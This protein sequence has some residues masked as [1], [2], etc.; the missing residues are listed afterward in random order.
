M[1]NNLHTHV[2]NNINNVTQSGMPIHKIILTQSANSLVNMQNIIVMSHLVQSPD[3]VT[4]GKLISA[5]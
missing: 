3:N 2:K 1:N 4:D 5:D